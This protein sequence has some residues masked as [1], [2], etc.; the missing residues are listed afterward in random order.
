MCMC[1]GTLA[2]A[3]PLPLHALAPVPLTLP[4]PPLS[5]SLASLSLL[6]VGPMPH[7]HVPVERLGVAESDKSALPTVLPA[8]GEGADDLDIARK[9][10]AA[11]ANVERVHVG[12]FV[13]LTEVAFRLHS[14]TT[15]VPMR[16]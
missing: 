11:R 3:L 14:H 6:A 10:P 9:A 1:D 8:A 7:D 16:R 4:S 2:L 12:L 15:A 13:T 5:L